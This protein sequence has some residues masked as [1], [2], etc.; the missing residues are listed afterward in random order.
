MIACIIAPFAARKMAIG[1]LL[2]VSRHMRA[3]VRGAAA[4]AKATGD[5][6]P[7]ELV[8]SGKQ[9]AFLVLRWWQG[10]KEPVTDLVMDK[11]DLNGRFLDVF[12]PPDEKSR[13]TVADVIAIHVVLMPLGGS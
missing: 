2:A 1:G 7:F 4:T 13:A 9:K 12:E 5:D 6:E 11:R 10:D 3:Y 8:A